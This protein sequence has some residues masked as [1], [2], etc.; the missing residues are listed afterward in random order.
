MQLFVIGLVLLCGCGAAPDASTTQLSS[1]PIASASTG[2]ASAPTGAASP[3]EAYRRW[4]AGGIARD[5]AAVYDLTE[6][7]SREAEVAAVCRDAGVK[8][9]GVVLR[10]R[11]PGMSESEEL[12][13]VLVRHGLAIE[14][15]RRAV[16]AHEGEDVDRAWLNALEDTAAAW[17]TAVTKPRELYAELMRIRTAKIRNSDNPPRDFEVDENG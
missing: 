5:W 10:I 12:E 7:A 13:K 8:I 4:G 9:V 6:P 16:T 1:P 14:V 17:R 2:P 3:A 11:P 15:A